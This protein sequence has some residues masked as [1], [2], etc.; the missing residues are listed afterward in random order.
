MNDQSNIVSEL[1]T[2]LILL[3]YSTFYNFYKKLQPWIY[4]SYNGI[5]YLFTK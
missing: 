4:F 2:E 3:S 1:L 5:N